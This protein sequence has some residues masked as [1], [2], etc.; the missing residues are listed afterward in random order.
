MV[1]PLRAVY[2]NYKYIVYKPSQFRNTDYF[3]DDTNGD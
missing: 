1:P 2:F 3:V